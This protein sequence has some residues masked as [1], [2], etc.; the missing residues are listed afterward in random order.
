MEDSNEK[1]QGQNELQLGRDTEGDKRMLC[2]GIRKNR[3][4]MA[5]TPN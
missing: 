2:K 4:A 3:K 5:V 1:S